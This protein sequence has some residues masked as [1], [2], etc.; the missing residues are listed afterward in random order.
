MIGDPVAG[1]TE[2]GLGP[3]QAV[4]DIDSGNGSQKLLVC[5]RKDCFR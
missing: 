4:L 2:G 3:R 1:V 5:A